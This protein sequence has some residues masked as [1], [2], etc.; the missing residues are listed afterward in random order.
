MVLSVYL[1]FDLLMSLGKNYDHLT[2][3]VSNFAGDRLFAMTAPIIR[4]L[5]TLTSNVSLLEKVDL[6]EFQSRYEA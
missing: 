6:S 4:E 2:K 3:V 1:D 5:S